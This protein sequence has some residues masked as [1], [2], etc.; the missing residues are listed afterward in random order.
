MADP[1]TFQQLLAQTNPNGVGF[2]GSSVGLTNQTPA[3]QSGIAGVDLSSG[4]YNGTPQFGDPN[5]AATAANTAATTAANA[6]QAQTKQNNINQY[7]DQI[8]GLNNLLGQQDGVQQRG[9]TAIGQSFDR[10][11]AQLNDS[12]AGQGQA[13]DRQQNDTTTAYNK[14]LETIQGQARSGYQGLQALLGGSGS[15]GEVLAPLA[16]SNVAGTQTNNAAQGFGKNLEQLSVARTDAANQHKLAQDDLLG[17]K[18]TKLSALINSI[19]QQKIAYNEQLGTARNSLAMAQGGAYQ[20][21]VDT[22]N[23]I[24]QLQADQNSLVDRYAQPAFTPQHANYQAPNLQGYTAQAA[25]MGNLSNQ[26]VNTGDPAAA[27]QALLNSQAKKQ[28]QPN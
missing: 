28:V 24:A 4:G 5:A 3:G 25:Q 13:Y 1:Q 14:N 27:L 20:T 10:S 15:A 16:V 2:G 21:P 11:N 12:Y 7:S 8:N 18:N 9:Q 22:N 19:D 17:Q 23:N 26:P 6:A